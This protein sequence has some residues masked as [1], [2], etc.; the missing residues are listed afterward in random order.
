MPTGNWNLEFQ[1]LNASR[2]Y[3][4]TGDSS[5]LDTTGSFRVPDS[6]LL[7][8]DL[9]VH[10]GLDVDPSRFFLK[11]L[12]VYGNGFV[13][14][15]GYQPA[16]GAA[17]DVATAFVAAE[18]HR[19]GNVYALGGIND[20]ADTVGS[21]VVGRLDD[22][23][24]QPAGLFEFTLA[25][26]RVEPDCVRPIVRGISSISVVTGTTSSARLYGD[27]ELVADSNVQIVP[28]VSVGQDPQVRISAIAGEGLADPCVCVGDEPTSP[29]R[30]VNGVPPTPDGDMTL[31]GDAC[32]RI[33]AIANGLRFSDLCSQP[34][35]GCNELEVIT[36]QLEEFGAK[37]VTLE[38]F[39][40]RLE[41]EV[42][43]FSSTVLGSRLND[44]TCI[45]S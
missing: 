41:A 15:V 38:G 43:T 34:C 23:N 8:L 40:N 45:S 28:V 44:T 10:D 42:S 18:T 26:A 27:I 20:Y 32:L 17:V 29:V 37:A 33:E 5:V 14:G 30:R 13:I 19:A 7:G 24:K 1:N 12:G 21:V 6:F 31:I 4:L 2:K 35:C 22:V 36:N 11:Q 16:S 39:I 9:P 25:T 3:P